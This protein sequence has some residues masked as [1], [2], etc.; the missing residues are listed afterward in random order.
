[1]DKGLPRVRQSLAFSVSI[2]LPFPKW[3]SNLIKKS[4]VMVVV[5]SAFSNCSASVVYKLKEAMI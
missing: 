3:L 1:M 5:V 2:H 4:G